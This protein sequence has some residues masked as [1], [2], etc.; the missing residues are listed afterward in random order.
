MID[1]QRV[2]FFFVLYTN[3]LYLILYDISVIRVI[4][5]C[6]CRYAYISHR[7]QGIIIII[8]IGSLYTSLDIIIIHIRD[9][10]PNQG[11]GEKKLQEK[12]FIDFCIIRTNRRE[13]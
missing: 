4:H 8:I 1:V 7:G 5:N 10:S 9:F 11:Y 12:I 3:K 13:M 6:N 2:S